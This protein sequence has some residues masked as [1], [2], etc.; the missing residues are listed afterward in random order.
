MM[1]GWKGKMAKFNIDSTLLWLNLYVWCTLELKQLI[2][3]LSPQE[4]I[5]WTKEVLGPPHL[6]EV[7]RL[8]DDYLRTTIHYANDSAVDGPN[9]GDTF[10]V[11]SHLPKHLISERSQSFV[12]LSRRFFSMNSVLSSLCTNLAKI[13]TGLPDLPPGRRCETLMSP[14]VTSTPISLPSFTTH[15]GRVLPSCLRKAIN[16]DI[17]PTAILLQTV[18]LKP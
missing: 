4:K 14:L 5:P 1:L 10:T 17:L 16:L 8:V 7:I 3:Y 6:Q 13:G 9:F 12:S 2:Y 15:L 11:F 18:H